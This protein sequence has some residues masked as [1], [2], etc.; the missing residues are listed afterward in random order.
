MAC[1][2]GIKVMFSECKRALWR[3]KKKDFLVGLFSCSLSELLLEYALVFSWISGNRV[4]EKMWVSWKRQACTVNL[5]PS[6]SFLDVFVLDWAANSWGGGEHVAANRL[7]CKWLKEPIVEHVYR[8]GHFSS[9]ILWP[10]KGKKWWNNSGKHARSC[11]LQ[12]SSNA[13]RLLQPN[14]WNG[15]SNSMQCPSL[16]TPAV[17]SEAVQGLWVPTSPSSYQWLWVPKKGW[18]KRFVNSNLLVIWERGSVSTKGHGTVWFYVWE[19]NLRTGCSCWACCCRPKSS[20]L[21]ASTAY[22]ASQPMLVTGQAS[23]L[24]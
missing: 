3:A 2:Q 7:C 16:G 18:R 6:F 8:A 22:T 17:C 1:K 14:E 24:P 4:A 10:L 12:N 9:L 23:E 20:C 19:R 21:H 11:H 5:V 15:L 13:K